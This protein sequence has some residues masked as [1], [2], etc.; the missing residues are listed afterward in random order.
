ML[1][2]LILLCVLQYST[3][4]STTPVANSD[5]KDFDTA[6]SL[7][8]QCRSYCF[9]MVRSMLKDVTSLSS[10]ENEVGQYKSRL[11]DCEHRS[12][13]TDGLFNIQSSM[14]Q[15]LKDSYVT[16]L[17]MNSNMGT[18]FAKLLSALAETGSLRSPVHQPGE[19]S[20]FQQLLEQQEGIGNQTPSSCRNFIGS[21]DIHMLTVPGVDPFPV[22][23]E[24]RVAGPGWIVVQRR[25]DGAVSFERQWAEYVNGFG[26]LSGEFFIGLQKL[27]CL[28]KHRRHELYIELQDFNGS[29]AHARYDNFQVGSEEEAFELQSLGEYSGTAGDSLTHHLNGNFSTP[30]Q[31][32]KL[33]TTEIC[34][35]IS[36]FGGWWFE[37][38]AQS[39]LNG[40]YMD[41]DAN[42][43]NTQRGIFWASWRPSDRMALIKSVKIMIRDL[44][45]PWKVTETTANTD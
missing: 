31:D 20:P 16:Q 35:P 34:P 19:K 37:D 14:L 39:S 9:P 22:P 1:L 2:G 45:Q 11:N 8:H 25:I 21:S 24:S 44:E 5:A 7:E 6:R 36:N 30:D 17:Q 40:R 12:R 29:V 42:A 33:S 15:S 26:D 23:C 27:H 13:E 38:C 18:Y 41:Y 28:T 4:E 10:V 43:D 32:S 3:G